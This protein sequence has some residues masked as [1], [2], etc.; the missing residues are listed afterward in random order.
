[1]KVKVLKEFKDIHIKETYKPDDE[2]DMTEKRYKEA[3]ANLE[4]FGGGFLEKK[5]GE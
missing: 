3:V 1:M 5:K 2:I 4:K